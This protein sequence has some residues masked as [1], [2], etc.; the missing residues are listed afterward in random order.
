MNWFKKLRAVIK[1]EITVIAPVH[2]SEE[3]DNAVMRVV[4][5]KG[6]TCNDVTVEIGSVNQSYVDSERK[7]LSDLRIWLATQD[8]PAVVKAYNG[9]ISYYEKGVEEAQHAIENGA[10][11]RWQHE[12]AK[13]HQDYSDLKHRASGLNI[14]TPETHIKVADRLLGKK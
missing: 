9:W 8:N 2:V 6:S 12:S 14:P 1:Q 13:Q 7:R 11:E 3:L 10:R 4:M 5:P